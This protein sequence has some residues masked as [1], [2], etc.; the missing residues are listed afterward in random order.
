MLLLANLCVYAQNNCINIEELFRKRHKIDKMTYGHPYTTFDR[1]NGQSVD[2]TISNVRRRVIDDISTGAPVSIAYQIIYNS[3]VATKPGDGGLMDYPLGGDKAPSKLAEWAKNNAF[4]FLVGLNASGQ[5][6]DSIDTTGALRN[7]F[8]DRAKNAFNNL[9]DEMDHYNDSWLLVIDATAFFGLDLFN[10]QRLLDKMQFYSRSLILWLQTYDLLKA[11]YEVSELRNAGRNPWGYGDADRN[12]DGS[13]AP[14]RKLRKLSRDLYYYSNGL[15]GIVEHRFAWK[16]NHGIAAASALLMAAQVLNDAGVETNYISGLFDWVMPYPRYSPVKWNE[17]GQSGLDDNIFDGKHWWPADNVPQSP[18]NKNADSYSVY[19]EGPQYADYGILDCGIPAM[20]AQKNLY[21]YGSNEPFLMKNEIINIFNWYDRLQTV[22]GTLP[23]YDNSGLKQNSILAISGIPAFNRGIV[24]MKTQFYVDY[25]AMVGGNNIP[26][27]NAKKAACDFMP[28]AGNIVFRNSTDNAEHTFYMLFEKDRAIDGNPNERAGPYKE[29]HEDDDMGSFLI[30]AGNNDGQAAVPLAVDPPYKGWGN[31]EQTNRYWMHNTIEIDDGNEAAGRVY[32]NP[33][34]TL[35]DDGSKSKIQRFNLTFDFKNED[36][37][38]FGSAISR[39]IMAVNNG[40]N[41]YYILNDKVDVDGIE[42]EDGDFQYIKLNLNGNGN[43]DTTT[44]FSSLKTFH[45]ALSGDS[46]YRWTYPCSLSNWSLTAHVSAL[47]N[48]VSGKNYWEDHYTSNTGDNSSSNAEGIANGTLTRLR[49]HQPVTK[50]IFQSFLYPQKCD[51]ALPNVTKEE[52]ADHVVTKIYFV[53]S[54]DTAKYRASFKRNTPP[55]PATSINDTASHFHFTRWDGNVADS[56]SNPFN[57]PSHSTYKIKLDAQQAFV[58]RNTLAFNANGYKYCEP[59]YANIRYVSI[60]NG[61]YIRYRDSNLI[62]STIP[63]DA[64]IGFTKRYTYTAHIKALSTPASTD[65]ITLFL[66]D[67]GRGVDMVALKPNMDTIPGRYDSLTKVLHLLIPATA[68]TFFVTEKQNCANCYFPPTWMKIDSTFDM[69]E[70]HKETLGNKLT[71]QSPKGLLR[72][73]NSSKM[74][75]CEGVY[76]QNKDSIIIE[77]PCQ[78]KAYE[79]KTCNGVDSLVAPF[80][81]NSAII[82]TPGS[83]LVLESGSHTYIKNGA[84]IYVRQNGS[85]I[86]KAGAFVQIGDSGNCSQGWGEIIAEPGAYVHIEPDAHIEYR[87]TAGD[88]LDRNMFLIPVTSPPGAAQEGVYYAIK[89]I[90]QTDTILPDTNHA[91]FTYPICGLDTTTPFVN[92]AWGYTNFAKPY[93]TFQAR[94]DT[95]CPGEPLH[96]KLN[97]MLNDARYQIK[98][99]RMDS[100][101]NSHQVWVDT[102]I[103]DTIIQDSILPDPVCKEPRNAPDEWTYYFNPGTTHRVTISAWND[104]GILHDTVATIYAAEAPS[105]TINVPTNVC[106]GTGTFYATITDLN[107][108]MVRYA[109]EVTEKQ[110]S[111]VLYSPSRTLMPAYT[112]TDY[113]YL[114][115][116]IGFEDYFFKGGKAYYITL[117]IENDCGTYTRY[118]S[119]TVPS[120]VN[121]ILERPTV[122]AQPVNGATAVKLHGYISTADSFRWEPNTWLDSS[123]S[124]TPISTPL[125]SITYVLIAKSGTCTATDTAHIKYNRY[126]NAGYNDTLCYDSAHSAETLLGFPYD[127]TL[128]LGMLNYYD[129][130]QFMTYYGN[131]NTSN[132]PTYFR[133]FTHFMHYSSFASSASSCP[134]DLY[135]LFTNSVLKELFFKEHWYNTYYTNFTQFS[136]PS[137][138]SLDYFKSSVLGDTDLKDHL[139]SLDNWGNIDPCMDN[140]LNAYDDFVANHYNEITTTWSK[141]SDNDT[142]SLS[143]WDNYFVA[144]DSPVKSSKYIL[145]VITPSVAEIDEITVLL[146]TALSPSFVQSLTF[147]STV[148]FTNNTYPN[149]STASFI[150]DF[151]DG[152]ANSYEYSPI[153]TFPAFDS[154]YLV[155]LWASNLCGSW[156]FCDT[157]HIDTLHQGGSLRT[158]N[159]INGTGISD[160]QVTTAAQLQKQLQSGLLPIVLTNYPN[161]FDNNTIIAFEIWQNFANAELKVTNVLG[162]E[163]YTRKIDKPIDKVEIDGS[164]LANG[165][166]YYAIVID[167]SVKQ[168]KTMSV[169]H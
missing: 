83:A 93:A 23:S 121:I 112:K 60:N 56:V 109:L 69:D 18:R 34:Y 123:A 116:S 51:V 113:G 80:S 27:N 128:L 57:L 7:A 76:L 72:I 110:D 50:T 148:Y 66:P 29:T 68:T 92:K 125:D 145:S 102:C 126:A 149:T 49:I 120:G 119:V 10:E 139:D 1:H 142:T 154:S 108:Q 96:I 17:L 58:K 90:L 3:A 46:L 162:Q 65:S 89:T 135:N 133:Y 79:H 86:I 26:L 5:K 132:S 64:S 42:D 91:F 78:T 97:R 160:K 61:T 87:K 84:G 130:T 24:G 152:S 168:T 146:D 164:L 75:M 124:L 15:G 39:E 74:D 117:T 105:F 95:L 35:I 165:L 118:D 37:S 73:G 21:P 144:K 19:A 88:T 40:D 77:G 134:T 94:N 106:E 14:R 111:I 59:T 167:G 44:A 55:N 129:A 115:D 151:G 53:N 33:V 158:I 8:R 169:I 140:I 25:V 141:I 28:D 81:N 4:V 47:N 16:R 13:C 147:D 101:L 157:V 114:P 131:H 30:Y 71:V 62:A 67:V 41:F 103:V 54:I 138:S 104:C 6:L 45:K 98:V 127:M 32:K 48:N 100:I 70:G 143:S 163:I 150:W 12:T 156:S 38:L 99:C 82:I 36:H 31:V 22:D 107:H 85:L 43:K 137:L 9:T 2:A 155:C 136:D 52:T 166:Y 122:Y 11:A 161:P 20:I 63:V 153:H 159:R